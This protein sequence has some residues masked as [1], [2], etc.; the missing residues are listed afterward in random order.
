MSDADEIDG[1]VQISEIKQPQS[2]SAG[3]GGFFERIGLF[4]G[5]TG[6]K[7]TASGQVRSMKI[8]TAHDDKSRITSQ[9]LFVLKERALQIWETSEPSSAKVLPSF[10]FPPFP[11]IF[12]SLNFFFVIYV[13]PLEKKPARYSERDLSKN[14][15]ILQRPNVHLALGFR[16]LQRNCLRYRSSRT[17]KHCLK[18]STT[19][20]ICFAQL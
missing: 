5:K 8:E 19:G 16:S 11:D 1:F 12:Q 15:R 9:S 3:G 6:S 10:P 2:S 7:Q 18:P 13:L 20:F 14:Q 17:K 4:W